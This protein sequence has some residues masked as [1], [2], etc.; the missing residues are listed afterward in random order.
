MCYWNGYFCKSL[1]IVLLYDCLVTHQVSSNDVPNGI[2]PRPKADDRDQFQFQSFE[3]QSPSLSPLN[4]DSSPFTAQSRIK[5]ASLGDIGSTRS[6]L[7]NKANNKNKKIGLESV[8]G[9]YYPSP[10]AAIYSSQSISVTTGGA[11]Y[12]IEVC[13]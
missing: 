5:N 4:W 6:D 1:I 9:G 2:K 8:P 13:R 3:S 12:Y 7:W 10:I 11:P